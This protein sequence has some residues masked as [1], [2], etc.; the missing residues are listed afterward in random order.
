M[1]TKSGPVSGS[2]QTLPVRLTA[3]VTASSYFTRYTCFSNGLA[4]V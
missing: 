3:L 1:C 2:N 4:R